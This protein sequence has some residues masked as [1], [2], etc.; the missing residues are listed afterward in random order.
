MLSQFIE[1]LQVK[2]T[3][4]KFLEVIEPFSI[5]SIENRSN[6]IVLIHRGTTQL[7]GQPE[8]LE[9]GS[10]IFFPAGQK[11]KIE[12]GTNVENNFKD[13]ENVSLNT[14]KKFVRQVK[15]VEEATQSADLISI[16]EFDVD[17]FG[18]VPFFNSLELPPFI[19]PANEELSFIIRH[20][21]KEHQSSNLGKEKIIGSYMEELLVYLCRF[22]E[23]KQE[24]KKLVNK[25]DLF[26]DRRLFNIV[27]FISENLDSDLSNKSIASV[28]FISE[29]YVGQFFKSLT[30]KNLQDYIEQKRL[31]KAMVLLKTLP[32]NIQAIATKVGFKDPAYFSRR[33]KLRYGVNANSVRT[34]KT[35]LASKA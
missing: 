4:S 11:I 26:T 31:E 35:Q 8:H 24:F 16:V 34:N 9:A 5:N 18:L 1:N 23:S 20:L 22:I 17:L 7:M 32:D 21:V 28:A 13:Y 10:I 27:K 6:T 33:F 25:L 30:T 14:D 29:D 19:I 2:F 15:S 3:G 12:H